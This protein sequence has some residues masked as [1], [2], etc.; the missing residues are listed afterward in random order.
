MWKP[1]FKGARVGSE[2]LVLEPFGNVV[3]TT[4]RRYQ[5]SGLY[6]AVE[7]DPEVLRDPDAR[8][9]A[10]A[11]PA[12]RSQLDIPRVLVAWATSSSLREL[13]MQ[14]ATCI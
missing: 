11:R 12:D 2:V 3:A 5:I 8:M 14:V 6:W 9:G 10:G 1:G 13:D 4:G 7:H